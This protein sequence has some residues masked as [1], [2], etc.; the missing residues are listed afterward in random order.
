MKVSALT[1]GP[2]SCACVSRVTGPSSCARCKLKGACAHVSHRI[3]QVVELYVFCA[4][5][6]CPVG[7]PNSW[8]GCH[9]LHRATRVVPPL[10]D[11]KLL[12]KAP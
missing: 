10:P 6:C 11:A 12:F 3:S 8:H 4:R 7:Y 9:E 5:G 2:S 1:A